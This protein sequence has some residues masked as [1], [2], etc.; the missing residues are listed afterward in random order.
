MK[1][2]KFDITSIGGATVDIFLRTQ[3]E[4]LIKTSD[5]STSSELLCF[6]FGGKLKVKN[7]HECFGGG[8]SNTSIGFRRLGLK[9][10]VCNTLGDDE[11]AQKIMDNYDKEKVNRSYIQEKNA[12]Q[13]GFSVILS[14]FEGER[15]VLFYPGA[16]HMM[17]E[18]IITK[19]VIENTKWLFINRISGD[20]D[21]IIKKI[22]R[23]LKYNK[24]LKIAWNPGGN[25]IR[26]GVDK[27]KQL[28]K[29]TEVI[30]LN[31]EEASE[32]TKKDYKKRDEKS[33]FYNEDIPKQRKVAC[34]LPFYTA[35]CDDI[36]CKLEKYGVSKIVITDGKCG[37][38]MFHQGDLYFCPTLTE[39]K[40][41]DSLG[42]GDAFAVGC[43]YALVQGLSLQSALKFGTINASSVVH[44]FGA[45]AGLLT[46]R[47]IQDG[48]EKHKLKTLKTK[49]S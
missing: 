37:A 15:T 29:H 32:F 16:N 21:K 40:S 13:S 26:E 11:W 3:D 48:F 27:Y 35:D 36:F 33:F 39:I 28:L 44:F 46:K 6:N 31:K 45:Q 9:S 19:E 4:I 47:Q 41:V 10:A 14:S 30:Y 49:I 38:Q 22:I 23:L 20:S 42:A 34:K 5:G 7:V 2:K 8:A 17:D 24:D 12:Y 1:P 43:T 18:S 25:Q